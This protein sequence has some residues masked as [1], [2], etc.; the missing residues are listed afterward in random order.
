M[1]WQGGVVLVDGYNILL[2]LSGLERSRDPH[3][4]LGELRGKLEDLLAAWAEAR[5]A[6]VVLIWDGRRGPARRVYP[7]HPLLRIGWADPPAEADDLIVLEANNLARTG[8]AFG[9]ATRD[10]GLLS[11]LPPEARRL[12][13]DD[14]ANDLEALAGGPLSG[15]H[16]GGQ[17]G[18]TEADLASRPADTSR[19]PRRRR[20]PPPVLPEPA[21][22]A[23]SRPLPRPEPSPS[24]RIDAAAKRERGRMRF[25]RAEARRRG[26]DTRYHS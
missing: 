26:K 5:G 13:L 19:L 9:V 6:Q 21:A 20:A 25:L 14:L 7:P 12:R 2:A 15:A 22:S 24:R 10:Q 4:R 1:G 23:A 11:R 3:P 8:T 17:A 16:I 18:L